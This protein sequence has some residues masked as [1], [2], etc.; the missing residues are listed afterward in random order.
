MSEEKKLADAREAR[1][2]ELRTAYQRIYNN[3]FRT[4]TAIFD[5]I[6][7]RYEAARAYMRD[8]Y[9]LTPKSIAI[10]IGM[11]FGAYLIQ[12]Q[13]N[14]Q[15]AAKEAAIKSGESTYYDRALWRSKHMY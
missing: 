10:P 15:H 3:P 5:P 8:Y 6:A 9:K 13:F 7:F 2:A 1:R 14:K 11:L 4:N 12:R